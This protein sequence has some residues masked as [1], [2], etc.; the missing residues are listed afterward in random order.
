MLSSG[1][2]V[3][4]C[5]QT[6]GRQKDVTKLPLFA[7]LQSRLRRIILKAI[8]LDVEVSLMYWLLTL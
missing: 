6:D 2:Q 7:V 3:V 5:G 1:S 8:F 4:S